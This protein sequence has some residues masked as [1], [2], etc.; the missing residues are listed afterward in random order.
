MTVLN[1][2]SRPASASWVYRIEVP[3]HAVD[4]ISDAIQP[5]AMSV[6]SFGVTPDGPWTIEA[7]ADAPPDHERMG[8]ALCVAAAAAGIE[9]PDVKVEALATTDWLRANQESFKPIRAG[10]YFIYPSHYEGARPSG[11]VSI[12]I[13]A[14]TA[15]GSGTHGSTQGCLLALDRLMPHGLV[16]AMTADMMRK[17]TTFVS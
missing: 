17:S 3:A 7:Y 13:D 15:F 14:A 16:R 12:R 4:T 6:A 2:G 11:V 10:R 9:V 1:S 8:E 5:F